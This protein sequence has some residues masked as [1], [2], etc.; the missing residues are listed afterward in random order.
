MKYFH[1]LSLLP[2]V[3]LFIFQQQKNVKALQEKGRYFMGQEKNIA[4]LNIVDHLACCVLRNLKV[5]IISCT[6]Q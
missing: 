2:E 3:L 6:A 4:P 5:K 1:C